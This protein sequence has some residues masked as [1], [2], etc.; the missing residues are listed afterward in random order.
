MPVL[1]HDRVEPIADIPQQS[2]GAPLPLVIAGDN[3]LVLSFL[4]DKPHQLVVVSFAGAFFHSFGSPGDETLHGHPL[5]K[6][7][8]SQ[9]GAFQVLGSSLI[10]RLRA[11]DSVHRL[12]QARK[13][14]TYR[15]FVFTFHDQL[16]ECVACGYI[17]KTLELS[18]ESTGERLPATLATF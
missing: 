14:T 16:F 15:H 1:F 3:K 13:F 10:D 12:H 2:V 8:L 11:I 18:S 5:Y 6:N 7:G 9:Y 4:T 17:L